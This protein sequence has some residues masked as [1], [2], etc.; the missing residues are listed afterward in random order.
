VALNNRG[1]IAWLQGD[2]AAARADIDQAILTNPTL[3]YPY[4]SRGEIAMHLG[5][6]DLALADLNTAVQI[7][8]D[9]SEA[10]YQRAALRFRLGDLEGARA[11]AAHVFADD[12]HDMLNWSEAELQCSLLD[13]T[14]WAQQIAAWADTYAWLPA[15]AQGFVGDT[16]RVNGRAA[17]AVAAYTQA[18]AAAPGDTTLLLRRALAHQ[19]SGTVDAARTDLERVLAAR[20]TPFTRQRAAA[21]LATL[22]PTSTGFTEHPSE[23]VPNAA[24]GSRGWGEG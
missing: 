6:T 10:R 13:Q 1:A 9:F 14:T 2:A 18:L 17:E 12:Q 8:P 20:P 23:S 22:T 15:R 24:S 5:D 21:L 3:V 4:T 11:D 7:A 19:A 16:L